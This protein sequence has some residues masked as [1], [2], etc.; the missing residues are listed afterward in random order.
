M[1]KGTRPV[2]CIK[3]TSLIDR[4]TY[5]IPSCEP[6]QKSTKENTTLCQPTQRFSQASVY[7]VQQ[8]AATSPFPKFE[9]LPSKGVSGTRPLCID[10]YVRSFVRRSSVECGNP[11]SRC[12]I[13]IFFSHL[14]VAETCRVSVSQ[15]F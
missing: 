15:A 6:W 8:Q 10:T 9:S 13:H 3:V 7:V 14:A 5:F 11:M 12:K 4:K 2:Q 1:D